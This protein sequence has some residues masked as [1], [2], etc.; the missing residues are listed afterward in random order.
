MRG[1]NPIHHAAQHVQPL[2]RGRTVGFHSDPTGGTIHRGLGRG[3]LYQAAYAG[4]NYFIYGNK[5]KLMG[6]LE[7]SNMNGHNAWTSLL[8]IRLFWDGENDT[9]FATGR[10]PFKG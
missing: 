5:M 2:A 4:F 10:K 7:Y 8:G 9:L 1:G 3:N 6:G